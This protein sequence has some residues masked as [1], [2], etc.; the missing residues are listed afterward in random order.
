MR[1]K[2][3]IGSVLFFKHLIVATVMTLLIGMSMSTVILAVRVRGY[4]QW[5][6]VPEAEPPAVAAGQTLLATPSPT[7]GPVPEIPSYATL[8]PELYAAPTETASVNEE[9]MAYLTFDD[10]PSERTGEV[11][12]ILNSYGIKATFFVVG[13]EDETSRAMMRR[14]VAEGHALGM[15]S[16]THDYGQVYGSIESC[17]EDYDRIRRV[18]VEATGVSPQL[19]RYPGG[20][21]NG[22][23]GAFYQ[24]MIAEMTR[25][26]FVYFDW[27]VATGDAVGVTRPSALVENGLKGCASLRRAVLLMHDSAGKTGTVEALPAIIEGYREAGFNFAPLTPQV[28]PVV[29]SYEH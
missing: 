13:R 21:I 7:A 12:D 2:Q 17:L 26:G 11:L 6:P 27:N 19:M 9:K 24:A 3:Y 23:N 15:H 18:I 1:R 14:I 28:V 4:Q 25:R 22:Y 5:A 10:G 29:F 20:S 16:Y 8:F